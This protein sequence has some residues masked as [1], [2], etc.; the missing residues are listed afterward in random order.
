MMGPVALFLPQD[1]GGS[2][3]FQGQDI[4]GGASVIFK[5][6]A[7]VRDLVGSAAMLVVKRQPRPSRSSELARNNPPDRR[8]PI[9]TRTEIEI[10]GSASSENDKA[11]ALKN[12][13][14]TY[15]DL[16]QYAQAID[17]YQDALKLAPQDPVIYNNTGSRLLQSQQTAKRARLSRNRYRLRK[18]ILTPTSILEFHTVRPISLR[19]R[20]MLSR[21]PFNSN[22]TG[23]R[24][25]LHWVIRI[26]SLNKFADAATA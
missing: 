25:T 21:E 26:S 24:L 23:E 15:Y 14:N 17:A 18:M 20:W 7:R 22:L 3:A 2:N 19:K 4:M 11:E 1:I 12:Q 16:G 10:A 8:R 5:R 6:P 13:G 9:P